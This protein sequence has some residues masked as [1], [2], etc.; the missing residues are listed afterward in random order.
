MQVGLKHLPQIKHGHCFSDK[1]PSSMCHVGQTHTHTH[2]GCRYLLHTTWR[3]CPGC[4]PWL[5][6]LSR[7]RALTT[8]GERKDPSGLSY[9][10]TKQLSNNTWTTI[11]IMS[12]VRRAHAQGFV[13]KSSCYR[14]P[15]SGGDHESYWSLAGSLIARPRLLRF[16]I[17]SGG[18]TSLGGAGVFFLD[19]EGGGPRASGFEVEGG[20]GAAG[21]VLVGG[22]DTDSSCKPQSAST[23]AGLR[24]STD[25]V[26][27]FPRRSS[28]KYFAARSRTLKGPSYVH[29]RGVR[30]AS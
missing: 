11:I 29:C 27:R 12:K 10:K 23:N 13:C 16:T 1:T 24:R 2:D 4:V 9:L 26:S 8:V 3:S 6:K 15:P 25:T 20:G 17:R 22:E 7:T 19:L 5:I 28:V 30:W 21:C 14:A 18:F